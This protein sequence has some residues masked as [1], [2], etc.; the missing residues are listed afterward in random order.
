MSPN[1]KSSGPADDS[2]IYLLNLCRLRF[3]E[4]DIRGFNCTLPS[5][6]MSPS[7]VRAGPWVWCDAPLLASVFLLVP[8]FRSDPGIPYAG[9][10]SSTVIRAVH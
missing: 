4:E 5:L 10:A 7:K 2:R 8:W 1:K 6:L 9:G 3:E